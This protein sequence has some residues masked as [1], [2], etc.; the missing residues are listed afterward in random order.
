[1][2]A[3]M[4]HNT[5]ALVSASV[6]ASWI[7]IAL[8][9]PWLPL[10]DP[11]VQTLAER[12]ASPSLTHLFGTDQFGRDLLSRVFWGARVSLGIGLPVAAVAVAGGT[13]LGAL[14]GYLG[15]WWDSVI[16][17]SVDLLLA[18]PLIY[19]VVTCL[20]LFGATIDNLLVIMMLTA[21]MDVARLVRA[22]I[23]SLKERDFIQAAVLLGF[24]HARV[25]WRHLLPNAL[26]TIIAVAVL[27]VA[28]VILFETALS[29]LGLGVQPPTPSWGAIINDGQ[30][31]LT[32]AWWISLFPG[33]AIL[34]LTVSLHTLANSLRRKF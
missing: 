8:S 9:A 28:D 11:I 26:P 17:R 21:W 16:M 29:F 20:L 13:M 19:L 25:L 24:S 31:A 23:L 22:E 34:S 2:I 33:L 18:F 6:V 1:M 4:K 10:A 15:G 27:R 7:V 5:A 12:F 32:S 14:A 3:A 30:H